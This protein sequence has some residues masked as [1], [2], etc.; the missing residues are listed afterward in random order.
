MTR[1]VLALLQYL[2]GRDI[3]KKLAGQNISVEYNKDGR[4]RRV[5]LDGKL[6]FVLRNNDGYL[7][8]TINGAVYI[9]RKVVVSRDVVEYIK[10]GR[11]VPAKYI[12]SISQDARPY[13]EVAV[14]SPEGEILAVGRLMYSVRE[15]GLRRG[16]AV[17]TR[18]AR[19]D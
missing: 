10:M 12:S 4:I 8:P 14:V 6:A 11:N 7:L 9:E 3:A 2:Y 18:E 19:K 13:G 1:Q 15:I 5:Y 17:K 16:Y